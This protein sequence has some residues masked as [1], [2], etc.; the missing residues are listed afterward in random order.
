MNEQ[1]AL[2]LVARASALGDRAAS[3]AL[4]TEPSSIGILADLRA[5]DAAAWAR[6]RV[7]L[8]SAGLLSIIEPAVVAAQ[9]DVTRM[10]RELEAPGA[11]PVE[12]NGNGKT[13]VVE[14]PGPR[15]EEGYGTGLW[16]ARLLV[17]RHGADLRYVEHGWSHWLAYSESSGRWVS[18]AAGEVS[19]RAQ[20][21][22]TE[23]LGVAADD[24]RAACASGLA[25]E[26]EAA[27]ARLKTAR[28]FHEKHALADAIVLAQTQSPVQA[29]TA[30]WDAEPWLLS[31]GGAQVVDLKT[32]DVRAATRED[33][34]TRG[35][36]VLLTPE[37]SAPLFEDV[38]KTALPDDTQ[39]A[40][41][42]RFLGYACTGAIREHALH[43]AVGAGD[44]GKST[45]FGAVARVLGGYAGVAPQ[46]LLEKQPPG[47][48]SPEM[49]SLAGKRLVV[50][51][52]LPENMRLN[53]S[54]VKVLTGGDQVTGR[55]LYENEWTFSPS[56][57]IVVYTNHRPRITGT[58][59]GIWRRLRLLP[60]DVRIPPERQVKG[61]EDRIVAEEA[62]GVLRWLIAGARAYVAE[63]LAEP[64]SVLLA[65]T[66]YRHQEDDL[67]EFVEARLLMA[68]GAWVSSSDVYDAYQDWAAGERIPTDRRLS[69]RGLTMRLVER[70][71]PQHRV[72]AARGF[73]DILIRDADVT[74]EASPNESS[75]WAP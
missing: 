20:S 28:R 35:T 1:T 45:I 34:L 24:L 65:T 59:H 42:Q 29:T 39:R 17:E 54:L 30:G 60:F 74:Q 19:R 62:P 50:V 73:R 36:D 51:A 56:H 6:V 4:L 3:V 40:Y 32:G 67:G 70:G 14:A 58:D 47:H 52:E 15:A 13:H 9:R 16:F 69:K 27:E 75:G 18:D 57:K 64:E 68:Q 63:G 43:L 72:N 61:L 48:R 12:G 55:R 53:E 71:I 22:A 10:L 46:A 23:L 44:N 26:V 7:H 33:R 21:V 66:N 11:A 2:D 25:S 38:V 37:A 41:L 5:T 49:M 8:A 31:I